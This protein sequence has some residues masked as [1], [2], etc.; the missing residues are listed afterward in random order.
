MRP[1]VHHFL[2][3]KIDERKVQ[4]RNRSKRTILLLLLL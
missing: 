3:K 2:E 1:H 4:I